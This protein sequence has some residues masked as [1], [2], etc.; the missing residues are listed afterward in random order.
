MTESNQIDTQQQEQPRN[1]MGQFAPQSDPI[2]DEVMS[3]GQSDAF[4]STGDGEDSASINE[5]MGIP[6]FNWNERA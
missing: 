5:L 1:E 4:A 3:N 6:G 2:V